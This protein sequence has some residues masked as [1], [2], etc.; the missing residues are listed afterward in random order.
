M[1]PFLV[2]QDQMKCLLCN[3]K[4]DLLFPSLG[5]PEVKWIILQQILSFEKPVMML[6][7]QKF[8]QNFLTFCSLSVLC[9]VFIK[10]NIFLLSTVFCPLACFPHCLFPG[11]RNCWHLLFAK[12]PTL[13]TISGSHSLVTSDSTDHLR[14]ASHDLFVPRSDA[15]CQLLV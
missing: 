6:P 7:F 11:G 3:T 1:G 10:L 4:L 13:G 9:V 15:T 5:N 8:L 2:C 14:C 12:C